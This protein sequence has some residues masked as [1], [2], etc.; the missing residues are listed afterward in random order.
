MYGDKSL[1]PAETMRL[2]VL[3]ALTEGDVSYAD[4]ATSVRHFVERMVGPSLELLGSSLEV[5]RLE[6]LI[7]AADGRSGDQVPMRLTPAG[8]DTFEKLMLSSLR[9]PLNDIQRLVLALKLRFIDQLSS[10]DRADQIDLLLELT[11]TE[12]ARLED[13]RRTGAGGMFADWLDQEVD[14]TGKR[15][16]WLKSCLE[17]AEADV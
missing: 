4:L 10:E 8:R 7:E 2:A 9:A 17:R 5:L 15:R 12:L 11:E 1:T 13:L 3:G 6:G 14:H 16:A